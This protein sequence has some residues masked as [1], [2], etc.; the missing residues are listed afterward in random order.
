MN[1]NKLTQCIS[2][3]NSLQ[4]IVVVKNEDL[5]LEVGVQKCIW[6]Y[7]KIKTV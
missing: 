1:F 2:K 7:V 4:Q 6:A 5:Q 3:Y